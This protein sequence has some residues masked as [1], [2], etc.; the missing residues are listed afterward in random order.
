MSVPPSL[1]SGVTRK[2]KENVTDSDSKPR[3]EIS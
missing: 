1:T 2:T 3:I